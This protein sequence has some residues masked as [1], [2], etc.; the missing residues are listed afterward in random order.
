MQA[1]LKRQHTVIDTRAECRGGV[2]NNTYS[3]P[4]PPPTTHIQCQKKDLT[5]GVP[6]R[7]KQW[8]VPK[9]LLRMP[10]KEPVLSL[11]RAIGAFQKSQE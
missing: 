5:I 4:P 11:W 8:L 10:K 2:L 9:L 6:L 3:I 1:K 7:L